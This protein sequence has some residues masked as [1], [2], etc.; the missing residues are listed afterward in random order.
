MRGG[1]G[2]VEAGRLHGAEESQIMRVALDGRV[3]QIDA[4]PE[5]TVRVQPLDFLLSRG[6]E[7]LGHVRTRSPAVTVRSAEMPDETSSE[8]S[9]D[10]F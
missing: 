4:K 9:R 10:A 5:I 6:F 7:V 1:R 8:P 2:A 3:G